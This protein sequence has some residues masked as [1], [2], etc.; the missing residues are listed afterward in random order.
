MILDKKINIMV[1]YDFL[2]Q[3]HLITA[4]LQ[5]SIVHHC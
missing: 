2:H 5:F 4:I 1:K 3:E